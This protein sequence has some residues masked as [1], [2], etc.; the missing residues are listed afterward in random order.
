[1][2]FIKV[3]LL[4]HLLQVS[5]LFINIINILKHDLGKGKSALMKKVIADVKKSSPFHTP[6][7]SSTSNSNSTPPIERFS[8]SFVSK[9]K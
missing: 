7:P 4:L 6:K 5:R 2:E 8:S 1:M 9:K 3:L